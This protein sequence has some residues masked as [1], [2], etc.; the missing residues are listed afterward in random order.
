M[1]STEKKGQGATEYLLL[2]GAVIIIAVVAIVIY[3]NYFNFQSNSNETVDVKLEITSINTPYALKAAYQ[4]DKTT[5]GTTKI[6]S[7]NAR[8]TFYLNR[9]QKKTINLG[10]FYPGESFSVMVG[11]GRPDIEPQD[12]PGSDWTGKNR[13]VLVE[14]SIGDKK[15]SYVVAGPYNWN[16]NPSG[17]VIQSFTIPSNLGINSSVDISNTR[18]NTGK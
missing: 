2:F 7:G 13:W 10:K 8:S 4:V 15:S 3:S 6:I 18:I 11:V 14:I 5:N 16:I 1:L 9:G 12:L 17:A